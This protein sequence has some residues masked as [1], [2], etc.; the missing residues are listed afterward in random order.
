MLGSVFIEVYWDLVFTLI[1]LFV[2]KTL[3]DKF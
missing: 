1:S 3:N 2:K